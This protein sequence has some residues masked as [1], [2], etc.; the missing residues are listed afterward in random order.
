[1]MAKIVVIGLGPI[2]REMVRALSSRK[3]AQIVGAA[4]PAYAGQDAG[5]LAGIGRLGVVATASAAEAYARAGGNISLICTA[6]RLAATAPQVEAAVNAGHAVVSTCESLSFPEREDAAWA[7]RI[8]RLAREKKVG[9]LGVGV[10]PGFVMDRVPLALAATCVRVESIH[11]QRVVDAARRRG[12]LKIKVG[13][14]LTPKELRDGIKAGRLGHVGL[15]ES[16]LLIARGMDWMLDAAE[17]TSDCVVATREAP[18]EGIEP[19]RVAGVHQVARGRRAGRVVI[20][21]D[22]EMSVAAPDPRDH[23]QLAGDPPLDVIFRGGTHGDRGTI[24]AALNAIPH[25][26]AGA[27]GLHHIYDLPLF[28]VRG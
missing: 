28:G 25:V 20:T 26:L 12:P 14:G 6:S 16:L 9:V 27:P 17:E 5:A 21:L 13:A 3:T 22:L 18:R 15:V 11:V 24:G 1:M 7:E 4:D 19:G 23:I 10:N 2:G 8:D